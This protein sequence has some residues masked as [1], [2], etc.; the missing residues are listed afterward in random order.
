MPIIK[1]IVQN[2]Y[3]IVVAGITLLLFLFYNSALTA[4]RKT[5]F[6]IGVLISL[7][8]IICNIVVYMFAGT[9][10]NI[11]LIKIFSAISFS[12]SG[13]VMLPFIFVTDV[14]KKKVRIT[15]ICLTIFNVLLCIISIFNGCI[16]AFDAMGNRKLGP[17]ATVPYI[18]SFIYIALLLIASMNK[19]RLG[20]KNE[21]IFIFLLSIAIVM[22]T[23]MN[24]VFNFKFLISGMAVLSCLFYYIFFTTET[25]TRDALTGAFNRHSFYKDVENMKKHQMFVISIDLNGLKRINDSEGHD[26]GDKAILSVSESALEVLPMK[27]RF[28]R[29]GGDEFEILYPNANY[30]DVELITNKLKEAIYKRGYSIAVGFGE[31]KK[32]MNFDNVF[33]EVDAMMYED[34][35]RMKAADPKLMNINPVI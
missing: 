20:F 23:V 24:A 16:F 5:A 34:K 3:L 32:G 29:M 31:Y 15:V 4:K 9:G 14:I 1:E 28:Y 2:S 21:S 25:L 10:K 7:M 18:L 11:M 17:L 30:T 33:R 26:A 12:I 8:M 27:C 35:A 13:P 19:F 22:A 6:L